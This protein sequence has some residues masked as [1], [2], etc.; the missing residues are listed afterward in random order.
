MS[1]DADLDA[2]FQQVVQLVQ[3]LPKEGEKQ[4][5]YIHKFI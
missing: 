3:S 1:E 2:E 4:T 5:I